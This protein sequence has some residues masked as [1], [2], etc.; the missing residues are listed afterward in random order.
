MNKRNRNILIII[1]TLVLI[2]LIIFCVK[3][4][5]SNKPIKNENEN[6]IDIS[7]DEKEPIYAGERFDM[8]N[9]ENAKIIGNVKQNI[10]NKFLETKK[11][12][13]LK[14]SDIKLESDASTG[15]TTFM[16][17]VENIGNATHTEELVRIILLRED[18]SELDTIDGVIGELQKGEKTELVSY[19]GTDLA[20]AY[21]FKIEKVK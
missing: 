9:T 10:S 13:D 21:D 8:D 3:Y 7:K 16:A 5:L 15:V 4:F 20:N 17:M 12:F 11:Y 19:T 2:V 1:S 18:G 14:I 6:E